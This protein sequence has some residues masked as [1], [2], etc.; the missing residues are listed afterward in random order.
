MNYL[1]FAPSLFNIF[2][3]WV[4]I[5]DGKVVMLLIITDDIVSFHELLSI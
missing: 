1:S 2:D 5:T 4:E 3:T